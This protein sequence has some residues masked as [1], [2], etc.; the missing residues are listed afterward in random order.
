MAVATISLVES[1][2]M[3]GM[4]S[5]I[6]ETIDKSVV[7][8]AMWVLVIL[9]AKGGFLDSYD[10]ISIGAATFIANSYHELVVTPTDLAWANSA[11]F[12]GAILAAFAAGIY[13]DRVGR[14]TLFILDLLLFVIAAPLQALV[15]NIQE[16]I[17]LRLV[18]G[19]A[20]GIDIPVAW[21]LICETAPT[22]QRGKLVSMMF[23]FWALGGLVSFLVA[24]A[25]VPLG[26][27]SWRVLL[28][29]G[30]IPAVAVYLFRRNVPESPRWLVSQGRNQEASWATSVLGVE[31]GDQGA[32]LAKNVGVM[33]Q[34][35]YAQLFTTYWRVALFEG[36]FMFVF[37]ATGLLL[38]LYPA[39]IFAELGLTGFK[40]S[41]YI[42]AFSWF[43]ILLG[44][45][46][47]A[48]LVDRIGRRPLSF[49]GSLG[50]SASLF[51]LI[52]VPAHNFPLFFGAFFL[53]AYVSV[54]GGWG[55]AW[56]YQTEIF[57]T[58]IRATGAGFA[59]SMNRIGAAVAAFGV[60]VFMSRYGF[61]NLLYVFMVANLM[62]FLVLVL[63]G[64]ETKG[65]NLEEI[66]A[67]AKGKSGR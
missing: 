49:F 29:S 51:L 58:T 63:F 54:L 15:T 3:E 33:T 50:V 21:T 23:T 47:S 42:G 16:L 18:I 28:A 22:Q 4:M 17:V 62:L 37:A 27:I 11:A 43:I 67:L 7:T 30:A 66:E 8:R 65:K 53:F 64:F 24:I 9:A 13:S 39:R 44:M 60:P 1:E 46:S 55:P 38:S 56:V 12:A 48:F 36:V 19:V 26:A 40:N 6:S 32:V 34:T 14:R 5:T 57:P 45:L 52:K 35:S 59:G 10:I 31:A 20:I 61:D 2:T 41:L 25:L